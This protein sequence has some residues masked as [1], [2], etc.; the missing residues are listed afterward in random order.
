MSLSKIPKHKRKE[1]ASAILK[2][3]CEE[4]ETKLSKLEL[5]RNRS[6]IISRKAGIVLGDSRS[7]SHA[8]W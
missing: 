5:G 4:W 6:I 3:E 7:H 8:Y 1:G 2:A